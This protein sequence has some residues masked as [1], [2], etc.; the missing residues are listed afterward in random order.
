MG[1]WKRI[2]IN[3]VLFIAIAGF[4]KSDFHVANVW[5]ALLASFV[6]AV[7]NA[8]VKPV[9]L[10]L[11]LPITLL[12]LG[13]FS[14]VINGLMLQLTSYFVGKTSFGFSS[15]GMAVLVSVLMSLA[16]V[17]VSNFLAKRDVNGE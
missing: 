16:N 14:I 5:I 3:T 9:L 4:F 2:I 1:F 10:L 11:S 13:L 8:A 15:F 6:L 17:I 7:L 12:T